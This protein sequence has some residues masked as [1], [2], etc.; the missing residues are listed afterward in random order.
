MLP[1]YSVFDVV[2]IAKFWNYIESM[3]SIG[4]PFFLI[5]AAI[6]VVRWVLPLFKIPFLA[7]FQKGKSEDWEDSDHWEDDDDDD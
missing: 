6:A 2:P 1:M 4:M 7:S 3:L 5:W